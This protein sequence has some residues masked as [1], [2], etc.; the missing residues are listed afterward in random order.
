MRTR[1]R[2]FV[3]WHRDREDPYYGSW[4]L[5]LWDLW[6]HHDSFTEPYR[7]FKFFRIERWSNQQRKMA[8]FYGW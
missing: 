2:V 5:M 8:E 7:P 6:F 3:Y 1:R 4:G